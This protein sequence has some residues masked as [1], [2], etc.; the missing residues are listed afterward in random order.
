MNTQEVDCLLAEEEEFYDAID[1]MEHG[2]GINESMFDWAN[3]NFNSSFGES[4]EFD[5]RASV[6]QLLKCAECET[7]SKTINKQ[8]ELLS[9]S[10]KQ[11]MECQDKLKASTKQVKQLEIRLEDALK[12]L[13][14]AE[15]KDGVEPS[16][17]PSIKCRECEFVCRN[18]EEL[19]EHK[20][21]KKAESRANDPAYNT[22]AQEGQLS[23]EESKC[24]KC[25]FVSRNRV[26][27]EEH[28]EKSHVG[29]RCTRC[30]VVSPDME[31]FRKHRERDHGDPKYAMNFKCTPCNNNYRTGDELME[32]MS[33]VHLTKAQREGHG[34]YKYPT[35]YESN[36]EWKP[37]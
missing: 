23:E 32:H 24:E 4:G 21:S 3:V 13:K 30:S 19:R 2:I 14:R 8:M 25:N 36:N 28:K 26:L 20:R 7:N 29:I 37:L 17:T 22:S 27:L 35:Y 9:K 5:R 31:S 12:E 6:A 34:L 16:T 11:L 33:Q 15:H 1:E 10:D 18:E